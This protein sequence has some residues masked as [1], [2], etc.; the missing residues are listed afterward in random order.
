MKSKTTKARISPNDVP[1]ELWTV[2]VKIN[3][4]AQVLQAYNSE[5][6][7][8]EMDF[9]GLGMIV[10][11]LASELQKIRNDIEETQ[12]HFGTETVGKSMRRKRNGNI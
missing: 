6:Q 8:E 11:D 10:R 5:I 2:E 3:A 1:G 4:I 9:Y 12:P 7:S